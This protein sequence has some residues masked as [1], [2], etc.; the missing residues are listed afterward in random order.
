MPDIV[1]VGEFS[2]RFGHVQEPCLVAGGG[3]LLRQP[4]TFRGIST[5]IDGGKKRQQILPDAQR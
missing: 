4:H 3:D 1:F 2:K 5:V